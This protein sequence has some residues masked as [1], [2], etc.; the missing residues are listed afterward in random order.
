MFWVVGDCL[1]C[2]LGR[3]F[4]WFA[5]LGVWLGFGGLDVGN[6]RG[7]GVLCVFFSGAVVFVLAAWL[8]LGFWLG[9]GGWTGVWV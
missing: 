8:V 7:D 4:S 9:F 1:G 5:L 6:R 2:C 3:V